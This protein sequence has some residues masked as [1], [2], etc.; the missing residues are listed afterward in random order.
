MHKPLFVLSGIFFPSPFLLTIDFAPFPLTSGRGHM[1]QEQ[2]VSA[3]CSLDT[4]I[5]SGMRF[6]RVPAGDQSPLFH[7]SVWLELVDPPL[8]SVSWRDVT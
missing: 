5:D 7:G 8:K 1:T 3:H 6:L 2:P 4:R